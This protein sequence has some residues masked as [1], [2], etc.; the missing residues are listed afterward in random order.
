MNST[1][2]NM[3]TTYVCIDSM[4]VR[5]C[6]RTF[7]F[8]AHACKSPPADGDGDADRQTD[9]RKIHAARSIHKLQQINNEQLVNNTNNNT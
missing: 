9:W 4:R 2:V 1:N 6:W 3:T 8:C 7:A 5:M